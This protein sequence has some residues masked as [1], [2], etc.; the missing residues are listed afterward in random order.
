MKIKKNIFCGEIHLW[1]QMLNVRISIGHQYPFPGIRYHWAW[2]NTVF[3]GLTFIPNPRNKESWLQNITITF[4]ES[5]YKRMRL[6]FL[7][8]QNYSV[9]PAEI[10]GATWTNTTTDQIVDLVIHPMEGISSICGQR[11]CIYAVCLFKNMNKSLCKLF[12]V[13]FL[14]KLLTF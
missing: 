7:G 9:N 3:D 8:F 4:Y 6:I 11:S 10:F 2:W 14:S 12:I 5:F 13:S 1:L